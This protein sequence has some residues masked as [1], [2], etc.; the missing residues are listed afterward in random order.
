[1][2]IQAVLERHNGNVSAAARELGIPRTTLRCQLALKGKEDTEE[3]APRYKKHF[4]LPDVQA[5]SGVPLDHLEWA[6]KYVAEK[7][8][9]VIVCIGDFA[10]MPSLSSYDKS[11][12]SFEGRRYKKDI[13]AS[14][15]AMELFMAPIREAEDYY[16]ELILTLGNHEHR[17]NRAVEDAAQLEG[18]ISIS[19]LEYERW[20]WRV[21]PFLEPETIDGVVYSHFFTSGCMGRPVS[22]A[23]ALLNKKHISCVMG[24]VQKRDI[25][26]QYNALGQRLTSIFVG[27]YYQHDEDYLTPQENAATW[28]GVWMLN[29]VRNG[30]FDE[31][32][33]SLDYLKRRYA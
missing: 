14:H 33:V 3:V 23:R 2:N 24:H 6:G 31:M 27:A 20:G 5:K 22:S 28:R 16:P 4:V 19:D 32:P 7:R 8:P 12:K 26:V 10:D 17:I 15:E 30:E 21:V 9:D 25:D 18:L 11:K 1:M 29:E 13:A